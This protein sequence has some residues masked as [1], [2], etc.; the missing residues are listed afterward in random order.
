MGQADGPFLH[1]GGGKQEAP[2]GAKSSCQRFWSLKRNI[3]ANTLSE[4]DR[5]SALDRLSVYASKVSEMGI[6]LKDPDTGLI[7]FPA[8]RFSEPVYLCWKL[9]EEEVLYW[10]G[11]TEGFRGRKLLKPEATHVR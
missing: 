3:D 11:V 2:G 9:G 10:H 6:E 4:K 5:R 8:M 7:D 1:A